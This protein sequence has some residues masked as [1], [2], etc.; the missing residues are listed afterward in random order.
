MLVGEI[1][2]TGTTV[3]K[4]NNCTAVVDNKETKNHINIRHQI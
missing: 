2:N 1:V 4:D 3:T